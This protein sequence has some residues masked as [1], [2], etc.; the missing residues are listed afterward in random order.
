MPAG[1]IGSWVN[2]EVML[3]T[4]ASLQLVDPATGEAFAS[5]KDADRS[6]V[7]A[8]MDAARRRNA[9]GRH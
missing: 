7:D 5:F 3:G 8:A 4:G 6:V 1:E 2:G 9:S